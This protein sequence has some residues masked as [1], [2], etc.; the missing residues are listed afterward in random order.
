MRRQFR[1]AG[2]SSFSGPARSPR[3]E[4][5]EC[6]GNPRFWSMRQLPRGGFSD[7]TQAT[8][9]MDSQYKRWRDA[10]VIFAFHS[11]SKK[12]EARDMCH[13]ACFRLAWKPTFLVNAAAVAL[14]VTVNLLTFSSVLEF[15]GGGRTLAVTHC[16]CPRI[17]SSR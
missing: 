12:R 17:Y 16:R 10:S 2:V 4:V 1:F 8:F 13:F 6:P 14:T 9:A 11:G 7:S 5:F 3:S 15:L